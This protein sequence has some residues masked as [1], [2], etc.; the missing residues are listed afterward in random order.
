MNYAIVVPAKNEEENLKQLFEA[1]VNQTIKPII[2]LLIDDESDDGTKAVYDSFKEKYTF[3][4]YFKTKGSIQYQ[5]GAHIANLFNTGVNILKERGYSFDY[6]VKMDADVIFE[7]DLFERLS[8]KIQAE[9]YGVFSPS[10]FVVE[11]GKRKNIFSPEWHS[12]GQLKV[13]HIDCFDKIEGLIPN[14][15]WDCAD[16][17]VAVDKGWKTAAFRDVFFEMKR[18]I[19]RYSLYEARRR[20]GVGAFYL[21][22]HPLYLIIKGLY[23]LLEKPFLTGSFVYWYYFLKTIFQ[24]KKR[25]LNKKQIRILRK[26]FWQSLLSRFRKKEFSLIQKS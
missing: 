6:V 1:I 23:G 18:P 24:R 7:K 4:D 5:V 11:N 13:Y 12:N 19:G 2:C 20:Q 25:I 10:Y 3:F 22:Y 26:L 17:V 16:N 8:E 14:F 15:G 9:K 21:G